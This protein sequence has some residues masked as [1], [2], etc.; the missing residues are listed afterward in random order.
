MIEQEMKTVV[1]GITGGIAAFKIIELIKLLRAAKINVIVIL[2]KSASK[3]VDIADIQKATGNKVYMSLFEKDFNYRAILKK[4]EVDHIQIADNADIFIIAP[5]TANII[6]KMA[7]GIAD[8]FLTTTVLATKAPVL[9][10]LS[11]NVNMWKNPIVQENVSKL[12]YLRYQIIYPD[13]GMLA[14]G[15]EGQGR[16]A[17]INSIYGQIQ[18]LLQK[19]ES[20]KRKRILVT[21]GGTIEKIDDVRFITNRSSG[22]MGVAIAESCYLRSADVLLLRANNSVQPR[23]PMPEKKFSTADEL[24]NL[25]R[26]YS[27]QFDICFHVAA[28]SD[29]KVDNMRSGKITSN[30]AFTLILSPREKILKQIKEYNPDI[31]LIAFKAEWK[32]ND[33]EMIKKSVAKLTEFKL[34]AIIANDVSKKGQGF[35][36]DM[37]VVIVILSNGSYKKFPLASKRQLA[38]DAVDYLLEKLSL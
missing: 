1:I 12:Q 37:N 22:K 16:L 26:R 33:A 17:S 19:K 23:Y 35:E 36:V 18:K 4:R 10:C 2:T 9:I 27:S 24:T 31:K 8:D 15:Y 29:F 14:C 32:L 5:A 7:H 3:I 20:L 6:G 25:L 34:D 21:A 11:M 38:D 30:K 13:T 28:V